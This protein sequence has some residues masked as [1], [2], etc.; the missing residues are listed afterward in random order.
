MSTLL[1]Y[2]IPAPIALPF[3]EK[4]VLVFLR[5][6]RLLLLL[7]CLATGVALLA[8][9]LIVRLSEINPILL[10]PERRSVKAFSFY[11]MGAYG[12]AATLYRADY[13]RHM[14]SDGK[15][16][17][18]LLS[19][20]RRD[21]LSAI[22]LAEQILQ[23]NPQSIEGLLSLA[24]IAYD[25]RDFVWASQYTAQALAIYP[26]NNDALLLATL[27][28]TRDPSKGDP[29]V[30]L[31]RALRT[32]TAARNLISF[33][34]MLEITGD[35]Q[36]I[37]RSERP[38]A[39]LAHYLR[40][41]RIY[42]AGVANRVIRTARRAIQD[43]DHPSESFLTI[44]LMY[45]KRGQPHKAFEAY[46]EATKINPFQAQ[47]YF[48]SS[49]LFT[50][51]FPNEY[52]FKKQAFRAAPTD[53]FYVVALYEF[54]KNKQEFFVA[55]ELMKE[56]LRADP[57]NMAASASLASA[58]LKLNE[59]HRAIEVF[60]RMI[61]IQAAGPADLERKAWAAEWLGNDE[62]QEAL[63]RSSLTVDPESPTP[64]KGLAR[65]YKRKDRVLEALKEFEVAFA[66]N[67]YE[68][69][70]EIQDFCQLYER[71]GNTSRF[72]TCVQAYDRLLKQDTR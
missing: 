41:L 12:S 9:Y 44:G 45:E 11:E 28:A 14:E 20:L 57:A 72:Q 37:K 61:T 6:K 23:R 55:K 2:G 15:T 35:L 62:D 40:V 17:P 1:P 18:L 58:F 49:W 67:A 39:L 47:A 63:L 16:P 68:D 25:R 69:P 43:G 19:I 46:N 30:F 52:L 53:S 48:R 27:I 4:L 56:A 59:R 32:G 60:Q 54:L 50:Q 70:K 71:V 33:L 24:Q 7:G 10:G 22:Q 42:D 13:A 34:N 26:D 3:I 8:L 36:R 64:H 65:L 29:F 38:Y 5:H 21:Y 31:N 51:N 66:M